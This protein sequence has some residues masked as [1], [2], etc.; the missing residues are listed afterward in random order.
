M[1]TNNNISNSNILASNISNSNILGNN[2]S[3]IDIRATSKYDN[4]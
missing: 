2:I 3:N 1:G 4:K